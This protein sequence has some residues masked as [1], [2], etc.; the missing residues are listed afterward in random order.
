M[1]I[2]VSFGGIQLNSLQEELFSLTLPTLEKQRK[3][4]IQQWIMMDSLPPGA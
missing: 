2:T 4:M 1:H 3:Q